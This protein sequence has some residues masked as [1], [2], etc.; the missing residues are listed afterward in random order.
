MS[1]S[2]VPPR[3]F[4]SLPL[5][6]GLRAPMIAGAGL[7]DTIVPEWSCLR[8]Q[9]NREDKKLLMTSQ[10]NSQALSPGQPP[11]PSLCGG[12]EGANNLPVSYPGDTLITTQT[13]QKA[14][15]I[16]DDQ[17]TCPPAQGGKGGTQVETLEPYEPNIINQEWTVINRRIKRQK[18]DE[19]RI[20]HVQLL[21]VFAQE[22]PYFPRVFN[23]KFPG[24]DIG[25]ELNVIE[26]DVDI[27]MQVGKLKKITKAGKN[28]LLVETTNAEQSEKLKKVKTIAKQVVFIEEHKQYN[29]VKGVVRSKILSACNEDQSKEDLQDQGLSYIQRVKV[30]R[31]GELISTDT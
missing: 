17:T 21:D 6:R 26:A 3:V 13:T 14:D 28:T 29:K 16:E 27:K 20:R 22:Q 7:E 11:Q 1:Y 2:L 30:K 9:T 10:T 8:S 24:L 4:S 23:V 15:T 18:R 31:N 19:R 5:G 12:Q 25:S